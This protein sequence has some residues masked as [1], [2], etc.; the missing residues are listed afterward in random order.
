VDYK[1]NGVSFTV[2]AEYC[3]E[4]PSFQAKS[5]KTSVLC[6]ISSYITRPKKRETHHRDETQ[7]NKTQVF[8]AADATKTF[9]QH[10]RA[11]HGESEKSDTK[12][13][14]QNRDYCT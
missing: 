3:Y 11:I 7:P 5:R 1:I 13:P 12:V 8:T 9:G 14:V 4:T 6:R 10:E 2:E